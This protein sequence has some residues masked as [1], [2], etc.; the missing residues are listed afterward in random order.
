MY[1]VHSIRIAT[2][3]FILLTS[4]L[5]ATDK[6]V[7]PVQLGSK[8]GKANGQVPTSTP[9][10]SGAEI[11]TVTY[12][13]LLRKPSFYDKKVVRVRV[14]YVTGFEVSAFE[15]PKCDENR[16]TWV[17]FGRDYRT[18][19]TKS[20]D[21]NLESIINPPRKDIPGVL[22][23]PGATRAELVV[24]GEFNG[25]K[26]GIRIGPE[27]RRVLTGHGH[28]GSYPYRFVVKCVEEAKPAPW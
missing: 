25:P 12:C 20:V 1:F 7:G 28:L 15:D 18:C 22:E 17:E 24:V 27:G 5:S 19:T 16:S 14:L 4:P 9:T 3:L 13:D 2:G 21:A 26:P 6:Q 8:Q 23:I 10:V 11:P